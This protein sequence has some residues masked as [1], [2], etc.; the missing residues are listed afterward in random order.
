MCVCV[1]L[2]LLKQPET[3]TQKQG[4]SSGRQTDTYKFVCVYKCVCVSGVYKC[5]CGCVWQLK[6]Q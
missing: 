1:C 5:V 6:Q 2:W 3:D 4:V